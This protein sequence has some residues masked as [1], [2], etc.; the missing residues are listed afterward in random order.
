M[1]DKLAGNRFELAACQLTIGHIMKG[2]LLSI[3][4]VERVVVRT[5]ANT[6]KIGLAKRYHT[7][8]PQTDVVVPLRFDAAISL[9]S[10]NPPRLLIEPSSADTVSECTAIQV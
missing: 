1:F 2:R 9:D 6:V 10:L 4:I 5:R 8:V 3:E 7:S